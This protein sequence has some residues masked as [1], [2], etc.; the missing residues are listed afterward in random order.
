MDDSDPGGRRPETTH[1]QMRDGLPH[2]AAIN[3]IQPA[4]QK[5]VLEML[6]TRVI[7]GANTD[8]LTFV[9]RN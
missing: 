9:W 3:A 6:L 8:D 5:S 4:Y 1:L 7:V 2:R